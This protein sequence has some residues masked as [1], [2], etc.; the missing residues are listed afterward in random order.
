MKSCGLKPGTLYSCDVA[1]AKPVEVEKCIFGCVVNGGEHS[2]V[3]ACKCYSEGL[4]CGASLH[5]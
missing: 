1:G 2:C 5:K 3:T 4:V